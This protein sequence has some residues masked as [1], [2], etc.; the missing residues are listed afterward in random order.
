MTN[1]ELAVSHSHKGEAER[2]H[3]RDEGRLVAYEPSKKK[4]YKGDATNLRFKNPKDAISKRLCD[5]SPQVSFEPD[6][7]DNTKILPTSF[8]TLAD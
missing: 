2:T 4:R 3:C 6:A 1:G 5:P 8:F 7:A